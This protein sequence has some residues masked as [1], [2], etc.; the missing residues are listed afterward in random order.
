MEQSAPQ[1][2]RPSDTALLKLLGG[3]M[4]Y[5]QRYLRLREL[6]AKVRVSEYLITNACNIRC[7]GCWFFQHDFDKR[8]K[9]VHRIDSVRE[10]VRRE[11][12]RGITAALIIG[13]EPT[14]FPEKVAAFV[15]NLDYVS[16][17]TNGLKKLP[18]AGFENIAVLITLFGGGRL[19]DKLR[20]IRPNGKRFTGLFQ[21]AL[22]NYRN[23]PRAF[24]IYAITEDGVDFIEETVR[25]IGD[26][27]NRVNFNFYSKYHTS[28][29]L[30]MESAKRLI[31]EALR[32][33]SLYPDVLASHPYYIR[34]IITGDTHWGRFG[35]DVCPSISVDH[36]DHKARL[37][38]GNPVLPRFNAFAAD[39][40]TVNFC[41]T[42]GHCQDCRDSQA[43][44]SWLMI[45]MGKFRDSEEHMKTWI[46]LAESYW[47]Q[48]YWASFLRDRRYQDMG[49]SAAEVAGAPRPAGGVL[50]RLTV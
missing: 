43:I 23:D 12:E 3:D 40:E 1:K 26:N 45:S 21:M 16:V 50:Q 10:F 17:S 15:E 25:R 20:A 37:A 30:R 6:S 35:Y 39:F 4:G 11:R 44:F 27:G 48:F 14:L 34:T 41:C 28:E 9:E 5:L 42:S 38:N 36:P 2:L 13:G 47:C 46:E 19:D 29:P 18:V 22:E 49:L 8:T 32:V 7:E 31:D 33:K 24:F